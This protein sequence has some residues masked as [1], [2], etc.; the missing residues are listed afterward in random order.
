MVNFYPLISLPFTISWMW[1]TPW[2][3]PGAGYIRDTGRG[4]LN[5]HSYGPWMGACGQRQR[6]SKGQP[7]G[8]CPGTFWVTDTPRGVCHVET[9]LDLI[10]HNLCG[11]RAAWG[12]SW[13]DSGLRR[14]VA[15]LKARFIQTSWTEIQSHLVQC[16]MACF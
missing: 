3:G 8:M 16:Q 11:P 9:S 4:E 2:C 12:V 14:L 7:L 10:A 1:N 13:C 6:E 15:L 5:P